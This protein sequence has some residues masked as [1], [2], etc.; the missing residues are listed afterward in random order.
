MIDAMPEF[1]TIARTRIGSPFVIA[2]MQAAL[3][4]DPAARVV[5]YEANG[6]FLLGFAA[7]GPAGPLPAGRSRPAS[8][9]ARAATDRS[10]AGAA[11]I[12]HS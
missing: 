1:T 6:G 4:D 9:P 5:G 10:W 3:A 8:H 2:A 11:W 12:D 7:R